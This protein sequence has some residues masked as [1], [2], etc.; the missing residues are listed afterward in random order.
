MKPCMLGPLVLMFK[1]GHI[2]LCNTWFI[3]VCVCFLFFIIR[4]APAA[5]APGPEG[6]NQG[7]PNLTSN[8]RLQQTQAQVDEVSAGPFHSP[9]PSPGSISIRP[10]C[11]LCCS[12]VFVPSHRWWTSCAWTWT[13]FWSVIRSCQNWTTGPTPCRPEPLSLR[14]APLNWR[15]NTGGRTPRWGRRDTLTLWTKPSAQSLN[16]ELIFTSTGNFTEAGVTRATL[17]LRR[18]RGG[19]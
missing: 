18:L 12:R 15:T 4:S 11:R 5:G 8:R 3:Y 10:D 14:R 2:N 7:P 6:A 13:R 19:L 17:T 16:Q 1:N 9:A